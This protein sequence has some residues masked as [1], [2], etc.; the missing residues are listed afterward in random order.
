M[1]SHSK[2]MEQWRN[3]PGFIGIYEASNLG[4]IRTCE[5]KTTISARHGIRHWKQRILKQKISTNKRGRHDA[6]VTLYKDKKASTHLVARLVAAAWC[7]GYSDELTVNHIDGD[8]LN[9]RASNLEWV[10]RAEN[11]KKG[12]D[13]G[14]YKNSQKSITLFRGE[15]IM[16]FSSLSAASRYL[17]RNKKYMSSARKKSKVFDANGNEYRILMQGSGDF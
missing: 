9:N 8:S 11:I 3:I 2:Y 6:R 4:R 15:S 1:I 14:L 10:T 13:T 5:G 17:G 16:E 12:F 7:D